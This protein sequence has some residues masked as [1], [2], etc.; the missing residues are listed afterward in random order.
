MIQ[1]PGRALGTLWILP[2]FSPCNR[3]VKPVPNGWDARPGQD[4]YWR[5]NRHAPGETTE[6][7]VARRMTATLS[8]RHDA[9]STYSAGFMPPGAYQKLCSLEVWPARCWWLYRDPGRPVRLSRLHTFTPHASCRM[10]VTY[11]DPGRPKPLTASVCRY[12]TS[13]LQIWSRSDA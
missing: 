9:R 10:Y 8:T 3:L 5:A 4:A 2:H 12:S 7:S 11:E 13:H 1:H 6:L